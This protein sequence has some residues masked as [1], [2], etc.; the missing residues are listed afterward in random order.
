[1]SERSHQSPVLSPQE[2]RLLCR[3]LRK[4]FRS[5]ANVSD[6]FAALDREAARFWARVGKPELA[7]QALASAAQCERDAERAR[8]DEAEAVPSSRR[9]RQ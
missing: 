9:R 1:M 7:Q 6:S 5:Q 2:E 4:S 3:Y 8:V